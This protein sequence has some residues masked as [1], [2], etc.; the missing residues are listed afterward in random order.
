MFGLAAAIPAAVVLLSA[1]I[2]VPASA[3]DAVFRPD[4][5][6]VSRSVYRGTASTVTIGQLLPPHC[7]S[8]AVCGGP[9]NQGAAA[10]DNGL[11][12][13]IGSA[14]NVW[15]NDTIDSSFGVTSPIF[16]GATPCEG[17]TGNRTLHSVFVT[18]PAGARLV[19][20]GVAM[21]AVPS[22]D[23]QSRGHAA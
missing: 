3:D 15:N 4:D 22:G 7:P 10:I 5:L 19:S 14:N 12:P 6:V 20:R 16:Q 18:Q 23:Y 1:P 17:T 2:T 11:F 8:T 21:H 13:A 9:Q